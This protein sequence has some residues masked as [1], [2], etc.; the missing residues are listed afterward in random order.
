MAREAQD[1][2]PTRLYG[3]G[4]PGG[5]VLMSEESLVHLAAL[6]A[7]TEREACANVVESVDGWTLEQLAR[8]VDYG[9]RRAYAVLEFAA[10]IRARAGDQSTPS[11]K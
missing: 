9:E 10:A 4:Q 1:K 6:V 8:Q 7:A 5:I 2:Y 11:P 3:P